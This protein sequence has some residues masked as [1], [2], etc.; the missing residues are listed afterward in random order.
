MISVAQLTKTFFFFSRT[1]T[2]IIIFTT[3]VIIIIIHSGVRLS[4]LGT[5]A[6]TGL[7]YQPR[8]ID[9]GYCGVLGRM[10]IGR[11]TRS[12]RRKPARTPHCPPQIPH[13]KTRARTRAVA[14][15]SQQMAA[16]LPYFE[17]F[18]SSP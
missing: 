11:G 12:I 18:K 10:N 15:G 13:D 17:P 8:M 9:D 16:I 2:F 3:A 4:P 7:L 14:V 5:A 6:T 1:S